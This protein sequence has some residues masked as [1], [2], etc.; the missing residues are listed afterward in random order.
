MFDDFSEAVLQSERPADLSG[1][2]LEIYEI[3]LEDL[4]FPLEQKAIELFEQTLTHIESG[5]T[6][7]WIMRSVDRLAELFPARYAR[8]PKVE[9]YASLAF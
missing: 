8:R 7:Q 1:D 6:D 3:E 9:R 2:D 5:V 4:A